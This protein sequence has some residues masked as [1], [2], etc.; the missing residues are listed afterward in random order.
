M[1]IIQILRAHTDGCR[2]R[3][4]LARWPVSG[5]SYWRCFKTL[6]VISGHFPSRW[7]R[8][9]TY[10]CKAEKLAFTDCYYC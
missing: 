4:W 6:I 1:T 3:P 9:S 10:I 2:S 7:S 8:A 5:P